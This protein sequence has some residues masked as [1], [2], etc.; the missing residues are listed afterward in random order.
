M[1][2]GS[3]L[4]NL[5]AALLLARAPL[6]AVPWLLCPSRSRTPHH[7]RRLADPCP[8]ATC[9]PARSKKCLTTVQGLPESYDYKKILKALKKGERGCREGCREEAEGRR[10]EYERKGRLGAVWVLGGWGRP[11]CM[12]RRCPTRTLSPPVWR[13]PTRFPSPA[14]PPPAEHCCNGTIVE[15]EELGKVLQ[16]QGDQRK[17]VTTFLVG[18]ELVKKDNIK[19]HGF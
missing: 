3:G 11:P 5:G 4:C 9:P 12:R 16:L 7:P 14:L 19:V 18:N 17:N 2:G 13:M 1:A 10:E 8:C 6:G 15:D